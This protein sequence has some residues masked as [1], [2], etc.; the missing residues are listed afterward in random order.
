MDVRKFNTPLL[1][2]GDLRVVNTNEGAT[3]NRLACE[4]RDDVEVEANRQM[5]FETES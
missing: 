5:M 2:L 1:K 4:K 3:Q